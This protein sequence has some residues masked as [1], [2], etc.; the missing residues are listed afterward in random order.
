MFPEKY[1]FD[2]LE[3]ARKDPKAVLEMIDQEKSQEEWLETHEELA[4]DDP[5]LLKI[6]KDLKRDN[7]PKPSEK[8]VQSVMAD[9]STF[10]VAKCGW[11][12]TKGQKSKARMDTRHKTI[13]N[14]W[15]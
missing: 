12:K 7:N 6:I 8:H 14:D 13:S 4:H 10:W 2:A 1:N 15:V 9:F 11:R 3:A 5:V